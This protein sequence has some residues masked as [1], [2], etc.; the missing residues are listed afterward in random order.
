MRGNGEPDGTCHCLAFCFDDWWCVGEAGCRAHA[1][2][3]MRAQRRAHARTIAGRRRAADRRLINLEEDLVCIISPRLLP[4]LDLLLHLLSSSSR[5]FSSFQSCCKSPL[6]LSLIPS[7]LLSV[8]HI[9][10]SLLYF[11]PE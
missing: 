8:H 4:F 6:S 1:M 3:R 10:R 11:G 2:T 9:S 5:Y 7:S